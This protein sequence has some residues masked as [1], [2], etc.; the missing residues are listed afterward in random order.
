MSTNEEPEQREG[1]PTP[2]DADKALVGKNGRYVAGIWGCGIE[3]RINVV[4]LSA[5]Y[6]DSAL[7]VCMEVQVSQKA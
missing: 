7:V 5:N 1:K 6:F 4:E 2:A 3:V